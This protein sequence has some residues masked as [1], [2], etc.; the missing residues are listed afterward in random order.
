MNSFISVDFSQPITYILLAIVV[1]AGVVI[2]M[3]SYRLLNAIP[4]KWLCDYDEEPDETLLG[5]RY[6]F[7][8]SGIYIS[9]LF[10]IFLSLCYTVFGISLYTIFLMLICFVLLLITLADCKYTIIPDQFVVALAILCIGMG[11]YDLCSMQYFISQWW[12]IPVGAICGGG[13][14]LIINILSLAIFKK[15]GMGFGDVK[16][17]AAFGACIGF[18]KVFIALLLSVIVAFVFIIGKVIFNT[19]TKKDD[20]NYFPFGPF[21]CIASI[22]TILFDFYINAGV[23]WYLSLITIN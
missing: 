11:V 6:N 23:Q 4:A 19:V 22:S 12:H 21:L 14:L 5:I 3:L 7:K 1:V 13:F 16:L 18:P 20:S 17:M 2:T 15:H 10:A 9:A 8:Q